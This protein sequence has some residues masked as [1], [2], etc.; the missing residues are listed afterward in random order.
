MM[1]ELSLTERSLLAQRKPW[2]TWLLFAAELWAR[3]WL[4]R[5]DLSRHRFGGRDAG[6]G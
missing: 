3:R 2:Q 4:E 1:V 5:E 6:G